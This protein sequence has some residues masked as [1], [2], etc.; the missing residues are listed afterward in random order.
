MKFFSNI[1]SKVGSRV[2]S[3]LSNRITFPNFIAFSSGFRKTPAPSL[4]FRAR[5]SFSSRFFIQA[6]A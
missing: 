6:R 5:I 4:M 2:S 3:T 1:G